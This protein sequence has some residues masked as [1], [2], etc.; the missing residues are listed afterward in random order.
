M[1]GAEGFEPP[2]LCSQSRCATRLRYAPTLS[3]LPHRRVWW[4][5]VGAGASEGE[6][7]RLR[8]CD[9]WPSKIWIMW[10]DTQP[11]RSR[12]RISNAA[13]MRQRTAKNSQLRRRT[14]WGSARLPVMRA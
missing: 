9:Q 4:C 1:V 12:G 8:C 3:I 2:A 10:V 13:K 7:G 5:W 14:P 6:A 11:K